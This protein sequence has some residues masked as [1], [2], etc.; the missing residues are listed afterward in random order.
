MD[1]RRQLAR[2]EFLRTALG[3]VA[4]STALLAACGESESQAAGRRVLVIGGGLAGIGA[5]RGLQR[6]GV[7]VTILEARRR[8]GGRVWST[9][10]LGTRLDLGAAWIHDV[11]GNPL[12]ALADRERLARVATD[13]DL[14][15]LRQPGG[16]PVPPATLARVAERSEALLERLEAEAEDAPAQRTLEAAITA[17]LAGTERTATERATLDW[18]LGL[19]IPLDLAEAPGAL[20]LGALAEGETYRGGGDAMLRE[21]TMP[22]VRALARG[23]D[24]RTGTA[25]TRVT[26]R[27][28]GVEVRVRGGRVLRADA[29]IVTVPLGVLKAGDVEFDPPLPRRTQAAVRALGVGLLDKVF[30]RYGE[31]AWPSG[32]TLGVIGAPLADTVAAV[33]LHQVTG[34]PIV[35]AFVGGDSARELERAGRAEALRAVTATLAEGFGAAARAPE[36]S[37]VTQWGAD[38]WARGSYSCLA[39]GST[40]ADREALTEPIGRLLLA[41]EHT[42]TERPSTMDGALRSGEDAARRAIELL[43]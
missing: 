35:A 18:L 7:R 30:L 22:L 27:D 24:I 11:R 25:V 23:L 20:A 21:G 34:E 1:A 10:A 31:R 12:T 4:G 14:V 39:P 29:C 3:A 16:A 2:R 42:S 40:P 9:R 8:I 26:Q 36:A 32:A 5:A 19:E 38:R 17:A 33:D 13:W 37:Y 28:R 41:G 6:A 43:A 15:E